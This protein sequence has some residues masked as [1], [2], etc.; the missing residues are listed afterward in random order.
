MIV[1]GL[2]GLQ[3]RV[4]VENLTDRIGV[5]MYRLGGLLKQYPASYPKP[6]FVYKLSPDVLQ[7]DRKH[8]HDRHKLLATRLQ[9]PQREWKTRKRIPSEERNAIQT[10]SSD[11][12]EIIDA[13]DDGELGKGENEG[14]G[15]Q[16]GYVR[17]VK[18]IVQPAALERKS[19]I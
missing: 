17:A 10:I 9:W 4:R 5:R 14:S 13:G 7:L 8:K 11:G 2:Q 6:K 12:V 16:G 15:I 18:V 3:K 19:E 1:K